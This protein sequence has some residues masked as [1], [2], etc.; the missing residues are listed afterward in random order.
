M[1]EEGVLSSKI[2]WHE[3]PGSAGFEIRRSEMIWKQHGGNLPHFQALR[4]M[5]SHIEQFTRKHTN[6]HGMASAEDGDK[7]SSIRRQARR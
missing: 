7:G 3:L 5:N 2:I 4:D 1:T 6:S